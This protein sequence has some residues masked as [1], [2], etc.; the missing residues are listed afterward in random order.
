MLCLKENAF[1]ICGEKVTVNMFCWEKQ[2]AGEKRI[3][4][5][6]ENRKLRCSGTSG[7]HPH[8]SI[9]NVN[10]KCGKELTYIGENWGQLDTRCTSRELKF[11]F[12]LSKQKQLKF[13]GGNTPPPR[14]T[15]SVYKNQDGHKQLTSCIE[16]NQLMQEE[17]YFVCKGQIVNILDFREQVTKL[18]IPCR[19]QAEF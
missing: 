15:H 13:L 2:R 9:S 14:H 4:R 12:C 10:V 1:H 11:Y 8:F 17:A 7:S 18:R 19:R 3:F 16:E 6:I 5:M